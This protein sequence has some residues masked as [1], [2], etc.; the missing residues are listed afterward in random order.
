MK[1]SLKAEYGKI[2][3]KYIKEFERISERD[4]D[5]WVGDR[6]GEVCNFGDYY[7]DFSDIKYVVDNE[8]NPDWL[9]DWYNLI[10]DIY[11]KKKVNLDTYCKIRKDA[12]FNLILELWKDKIPENILFENYI[13]KILL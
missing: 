9:F 5:S 3:E 11:E 1:E 13:L 10:L 12:K 8:I 2:V 7:I 4:F 6:I